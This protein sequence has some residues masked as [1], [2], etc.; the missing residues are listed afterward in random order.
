MATNDPTLVELMGFGWDDINP[1]TYAK[2]GAKLIGQGVKAVTDPLG[3]GGIR[4]KIA[5]LTNNPVIRAGTYGIALTTPMGWAA[6]GHNPTR[7]LGQMVDHT[8]LV[9]GGGKVP[10]YG[11]AAIADTVRSFGA[12]LKGAKNGNAKSKAIIANTVK[13]AKAGDAGAKGAVGLI[14]AMQKKLS[15]LTLVVP[16]TSAGMAAVR[17]ASQRP[18]FPARV[19]ATTAQ[20]AKGNQ[21]AL[22]ASAVITYTMRQ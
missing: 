17:A 3:L 11:P 1:L 22:T 4:K 15:E 20:A 6:R 14:Q 2:K 8:A 10:N 5:A 19:V 21:A 18:D 16:A 13:A 9:T 12:I 7:S